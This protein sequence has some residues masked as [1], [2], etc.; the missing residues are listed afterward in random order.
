MASDGVLYEWNDKELQVMVAKSIGHI[1]D[2]TPVMKSFSEYMVKQTDDRFQNETAPDGSGWEKLADATRARKTKLGKRDKILQQDGYLC[3]VHPAAD[4][5]S[6]G[7][8]SDRIYA[9]IHNRGGMAGPG[10]KVKIPKREFL[11]FSSED[12]KEFQDTVAD[13]VVLGRNPL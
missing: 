3:L 13:Y 2:M 4:K 8:Y 5:D 9:A 7:I 1:Q 11:G 6:A 10:R 12:I